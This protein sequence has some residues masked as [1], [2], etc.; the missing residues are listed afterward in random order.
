MQILFT[1]LFILIFINVLQNYVNIVVLR[2]V[3][4]FINNIVCYSVQSLV[5]QIQIPFFFLNKQV[6]VVGIAYLKTILIS[7][8]AFEIILRNNIQ[9]GSGVSTIS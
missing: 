8:K 1:E 6:N 7:D 9:C 3:N 2:S 5:I 4:A